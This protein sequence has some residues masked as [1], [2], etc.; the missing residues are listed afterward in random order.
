MDR[1]E[2]INFIKQ[3]SIDNFLSIEDIEYAS[4]A[5]N[6]SFHEIVKISLTNNILPRL[7]QSNQRLIK[8]QE[9]LILHNSCVA[10]VGCGGLGGHIIEMLARIGVG[11]LICIDHDSFKEE[12][13]NRQ[14]FC[15][16][17]TLGKPKVEIILEELKNINPAVIIRPYVIQFRPEKAEQ[18]LKDAQVVVDALDSFEARADLATSCI[19]LSLPLVHGAIAGWYGQIGVQGNKSNKF[20]RFF[21]SSSGKKELQSVLGNPSFMPTLIAS[22]Q[23]AETIKILLNKSSVIFDKMIFFDLLAM[24]FETA[25]L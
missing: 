20:Q 9:Q 18:L 3:R 5:S 8:L 15:N 13:L 16:L 1:E 2:L 14:R 7:Y 12:N 24:T 6:L 22:M 19:K 23:V 21:Q 10:I 11:C 4:N 25:Q 17:K